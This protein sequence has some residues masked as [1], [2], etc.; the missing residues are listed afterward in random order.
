[1]ST[2]VDGQIWID[3]NSPYKLKYHIKGKDYVVDTNA[4]YKVDSSIINA[5]PTNSVCLYAGTV[6]KL[7]SEEG[8]GTSRITPAKFPDDIDNVIGVVVNDV[9]RTADENV[10]EA[11]EAIISKTGYLTVN[12]PTSVFVEAVGS[13]NWKKPEDIAN[14]IGAPVY[15]FIGE[16]TKTTE[17]YGYK[18]ATNL[19][20]K[21]TLHTPA[22]VEVGTDSDDSSRN[23]GYSNLPQVGVVTS[24]TTLGEQIT[25]VE[26][27]LN[28]ARFNPTIEWT[29]PLN[30]TDYQDKKV[31]SSEEGKGAIITIRHGLFGDNN[32]NYNVKNY[33][34]I[35]A[36]EEHED[37]SKGDNIEYK[38]E[39]PVH[40]IY[41]GDDRKTEVQIYS[42][43]PLYYRIRGSVSF[44]YDKGVNK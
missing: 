20:G 7:T 37:E 39:A 22:G 9:V 24:Y 21:L 5:A 14:L 33:C 29:W 26:I 4:T 13:T 15:W 44:K 8:L 38:I 16:T 10:L 42:P 31:A 2:R 17:G 1:M 41:L 27:H 40:N 6:V 34:D 12:N 32:N 25:S 30:H 28:F 19:K 18:S 23:V 35:M 11:T 36:L 3:K 43:E